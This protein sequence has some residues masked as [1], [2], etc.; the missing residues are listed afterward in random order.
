MYIEILAFLKLLQL[1]LEGWSVLAQSEKRSV[2]WLVLI[3]GVN[4]K[5]NVQH[6]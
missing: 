3:F 6:V 4:I 1:S 2:C 5:K